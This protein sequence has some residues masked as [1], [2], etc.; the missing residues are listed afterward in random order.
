GDGLPLPLVL[1]RRGIESA[2]LQAVHDRAHKTMTTTASPQ[3]DI[4]EL[5]KHR[6][7]MFKFAMLQL[8]NETHA[9]ACVQEALVAAIQ[10]ADRFA[11]DSAVRTWLIGILK[12][13]IL[14]HFRKVSREGT[15]SVTDEETSL[16]D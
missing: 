7:A 14:D 15:V 8:R 4:R 11:G 13:K 16:D 12:H 6:R 2:R 9:E 10:C 3:I 5:E 1:L